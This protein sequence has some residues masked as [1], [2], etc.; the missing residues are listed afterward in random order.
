MRPE[1]ARKRTYTNREDAEEAC[2]RAYLRT[3][4]ILNAYRCSA[5]GGFHTGH[6]SKRRAAHERRLLARLNDPA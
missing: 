6:P 2:L 4:A 3:G 5:C 1:C